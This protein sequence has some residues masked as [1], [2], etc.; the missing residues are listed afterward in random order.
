MKRIEQK[1]INFIADNN[2]ININDKILIALSGGPDSVFLL[3]FL[4]KYQRKYRVELSAIHINHMIRGKDALEDQEFC[5]KLSVSLGIKYYTVNRNVKLFARKNKLSV[6]EAGRILRYNEFNKTIKNYG[7]NK[8]ATAHNCSDNAETVLL[9]LIKGAGLKGLSGIPVKRD[10]IIRPV[11]CLTKAEILEYLD[12]YKVDYRID[13]TNLGNDYERSFIRNSIVP[14]IKEKLNPDFENTA[15]HST[16]IF[17]NISSYVDKQTK[18]IFKDTYIFNNEDLKIYISKLKELEPEIEGYFFKSVLYENFGLQTTFSDYKSLKS[19]I[20][21]EAGKEVYLSN[22]FKAYRD[23]EFIIIL[24]NKIAEKFKPANIKVGESIR[25]NEKSLSVVGVDE[26]PGKFSGNKLTEFI[27]GDNISGDFIL[28]PWHEGERFFP[29][30]L[31]GSQKVSDF[32]NGQKISS[33]K[34][35]EQL[36]LTNK[37]R[38]VWVL[39]LRLDDRFKVLKNTEKVIKLCLK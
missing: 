1:V 22:N 25:I 37:D 5:R 6:E 16:E 31:K 20:Q 35:K 33:L 11:L 4:V 27:S 32:L 7:Y 34:K 17:K 28:R 39:G 9:N 13:R 24:R 29:I 15:F 23:R 3:H 19:L 30:G 36:V 2:L 26:I 14:L 10:E 21:K 38:I 8:V 18:S 12:F